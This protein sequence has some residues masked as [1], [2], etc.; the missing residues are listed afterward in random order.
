MS[1]FLAE[2]TIVR[3]RTLDLR[4][5]KVHGQPRS[6]A[7]G[8]VGSLPRRSRS[9][10]KIITPWLRIM[11]VALGVGA[12]V[13]PLHAAADTAAPHGKAAAGPHRQA[14]AKP[15]KQP[16]ATQAACREDLG[17]TGPTW[18]KT[19]DPCIRNRRLS[20]ILIP[21]SHDSVTYGFWGTFFEPAATQFDD[22]AS[23]LNA[24]VRVFDIRVKYDLSGLQPPGFY[25]NHS[26]VITNIPLSQIF[27]D[28]ATWARAPGHE[29]E[30]IMFSLAIDQ[31]GTQF[32]PTDECKVLAFLM[33]SN[34]VSPDVLRGLFG[35][36]DPGELT[37]DQLWSVP[38][39]WRS[40]HDHGQPGLPQRRATRGLPGAAVGSHPAAG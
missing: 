11:L 10:G 14:T 25:G 40:T 36:A 15:P 22:F 27:T 4:P 3:A 8:P 7:T 24:G 5:A 31:S 34:L 35:T 13:G 9:L 32:F 30:I 21:G 37:L 20:D 33:Q 12:V 19:L 1:G 23:Q 28:L 6:T 26:F 29:Q 18:M 38:T 39:I 2:R 16:T 17:A